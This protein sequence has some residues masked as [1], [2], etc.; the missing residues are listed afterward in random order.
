MKEINRQFVIFGNFN[1][2]T[3]DSV[4]KLDR[5]RE[6]YNL[7]INA[8][9]DIILPPNDRAQKVSIGIGIPQSRPVF[10]TPDQKITV[11]FGTNRIHV[12]ELECDSESYN[13]YNTMA[14]EIICEIIQQLNLKV[15]RV[16][17]N[18]R[19]FND[20]SDWINNSFHKIFKPADFYSGNSEEWQFRIGSK[21]YFSEIDCEVN[22]IA[23][24]TRGIFMDNFRNNQNG[25]IAGYDIN[26]PPNIERLFTIDEIKIFNKI[27][28]K[29]RN[30]F[31]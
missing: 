18:G 29:Y 31:I 14:E 10:Q 23:N 19:L 15:I 12:E 8:M 28:Q 30:Y 24:Y 3:F 17:L 13:E 16:A 20:D 21:E 22:K 4:F 25:V 7:S 6:K 27:A 5:I 11:F 26:T 1:A 2:V 9:P